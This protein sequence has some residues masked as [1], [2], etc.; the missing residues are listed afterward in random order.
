M[1]N[2][3][4]NELG[5]YDEEFLRRRTNGTYLAGRR[6]EHELVREGAVSRT[7]RTQPSRIT[8]I[9]PSSGQTR[10]S[11]IGESPLFPVGGVS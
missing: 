4:L 5:I 11:S 7:L 8:S 2:V 3:L 10:V 6:I 1:L 9:T